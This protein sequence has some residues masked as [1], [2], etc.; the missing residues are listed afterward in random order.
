VEGVYAA[1]GIRFRYPAAWQL[2][3]QEAGGE[4]SIAVS[5]PE[6]SFWSLSLFFDR[7]QPEQV[8]ESALD[9]FREE[10]D[11]ID[12]YPVSANLCR[13]KN[14]A[15]DVEFV[16]LDLLNSA[17]LRAF[18]TA[19]FTALVLYQGTDHELEDETQPLLEAISNSLQCD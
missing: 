19:R 11:E 17:F 15:R 7:P 18:R 1:H 4:V 10:Y 13:Q 9:A 3:E 6:T 2:T 12:I 8:M 16:C 5:S 14:L